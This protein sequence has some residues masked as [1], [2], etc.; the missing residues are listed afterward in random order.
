MARNRA[1]YPALLCLNQILYEA[2]GDGAKY[3]A[4]HNAHKIAVF[5]S[6]VHGVTRLKATSLVRTL[7]HAQSFSSQVRPSAGLCR[8]DES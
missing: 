4:R 1:A 7:T 6:A 5:G 2:T 3:L 8:K